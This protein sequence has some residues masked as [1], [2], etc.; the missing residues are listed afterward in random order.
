VKRIL[1]DHN[2]DETRKRC[3]YCFGALVG[4][5]RPMAGEVQQ[6]ADELIERHLRLLN[7]KPQ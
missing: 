5:C 6:L 2:P 1:S 3:I 7:E 4:E